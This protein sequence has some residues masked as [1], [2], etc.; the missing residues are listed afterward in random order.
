V[1][2]H[3]LFEKIIT[4]ILT[5]VATLAL[6]RVWASLTGEY[7][8]FST[9]GEP[10]PG[11]K[12]SLC[13]VG[14]RTLKTGSKIADDLSWSGLL[15]LSDDL[16]GCY[17]SGLFQYA[18]IVGCGNHQTQVNNKGVNTV[19]GDTSQPFSYVLRRF[20]GTSDA[21]PTASHSPLNAKS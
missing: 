12:V 9:R 7:A 11:E 20:K 3:S 4:A 5:S 17:G 19:G 6:V 18:S 14:G 21:G 10:V 8:V 16:P 13:Y 2:L 15:T 1:D